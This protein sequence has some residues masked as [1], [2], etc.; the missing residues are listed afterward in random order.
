MNVEHA[1]YGPC[2]ECDMT[3]FRQIVFRNIK[4]HLCIKC[5]SGTWGMLGKIMRNEGGR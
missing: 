2:V 5:C 3:T 4:I 1:E